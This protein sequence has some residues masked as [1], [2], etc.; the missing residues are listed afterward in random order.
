MGYTLFFT[1]E[2]DMPVGCLKIWKSVEKIDGLDQ[3]F[4]E[5]CHIYIYYLRFKRYAFIWFY[6]MPE[7]RGGLRW[8]YNII[9][10]YIY[11]HLF[12]D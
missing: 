8:W 6:L 3:H 12:S 5:P 7:V 9:I 4:S 11:I 1:I 2:C 10:I